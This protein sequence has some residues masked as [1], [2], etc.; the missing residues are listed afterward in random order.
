[1]SVINL[2]Y[3]IAQ[4]E[5]YNSNRDKSIC[6]LNLFFDFDNIIWSYTSCITGRNF[7]KVDNQAMAKIAEI[8]KTSLSLDYSVDSIEKMILELIDTAWKKE[9]ETLTRALR[10]RSSEGGVKFEP[11]LLGSIVY[12]SHNDQ[13]VFGRVEEVIDDYL[14]IIKTAGLTFK[15]GKNDIGVIELLTPSEFSKIANFD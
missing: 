9:G 11:S 12:F 7:S 4:H 2:G 13:P 10:Y 15:R 14:L 1:M 3:A 8:L 5:I 6:Y